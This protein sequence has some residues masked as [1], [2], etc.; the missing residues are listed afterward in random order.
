MNALTTELHLAP[1]N[2]KYSMVEHMLMLQWVI[3]SI[4]PN[5]PIELFLVQ[6][7]SP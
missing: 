1:V 3:R 2:T 5:G 4:T 7:S 6:A